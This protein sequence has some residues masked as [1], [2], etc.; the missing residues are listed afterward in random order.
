MA[1]KVSKPRSKNANSAAG[2]AEAAGDAKRAAALL[3]E[4]TALLQSGRV[5]TKAIKG[6]V[7]AAAAKKAK[8]PAAGVKAAGAVADQP[9][10]EPKRKG[11][12]ASPNARSNLVKVAHAALRASLK[13]PV[14]MTLPQ[15]ERVWIGRDVGTEMTRHGWTV[16]QGAFV[17]GM[18]G[19]YPFQRLLKS[20]E[21]LTYPY[22]LLLRMFREHG[23][24][25]LG[26]VRVIDVFRRVYRDV[27]EE[28][29]GRPSADVAH[30]MLYV[31]FAGMLG[32]STFAS[33]R[34]VEQGK[35]VAPALDVAL[36]K[37]MEL[38]DP[39]AALE[40]AAIQTWRARGIDFEKHFPMPR[41]VDLENEKGEL[42]GH[43]AA[44][45]RIPKSRAMLG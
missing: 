34:W 39:R 5:P 9:K 23:G 31:R 41:V 40:S 13:G 6:L 3:A 12:K 29:R 38:E 42:I 8:A 44:G 36:L 30:V 15:E 25:P 2:E 28:F 17:L 11:R 24:A 45:G 19:A 4:L 16:R 21:P 26:K 22:E 18:P 27:F 43:A 14:D 33:Y 20:P 32:K 7:N 35:S 37:A 1:E 10:R